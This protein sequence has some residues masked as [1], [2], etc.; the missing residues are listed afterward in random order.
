MKN[1]G[2]IM[3]LAAALVLM[4]ALALA[5]DEPAPGATPPP[6]AKPA[7]NAPGAPPAGHLAPSAAG[8]W[9][10]PQ[11]PADQFPILDS[12]VFKEEMARHKKA[13]EEITAPLKDVRQ[14]LANDIKALRDKYF[15]PPAEGEQWAPPTAETVQEFANK[16][17]EL[18]EKSQNDNADLLKEVGGKL[19]DEFL[20]H[21][22]NIVKITQDNKDKIV[23]EQWKK[24]IP[25]PQLRDLFRQWMEERFGKPPGQNPGE[26]A[27]GEPTTPPPP[28]GP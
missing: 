24:L 8:M 11:Q 15:P 21:Q 6:D 19:V 1:Y 2:K 3:L 14:K 25:V 28:P 17:K 18:A 23:A 9:A 12:A 7:E 27:P 26:S 20:T 16:V 5:A 10:Q 13:V 22:Q 4:P